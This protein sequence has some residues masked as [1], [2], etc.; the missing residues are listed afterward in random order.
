MHNSLGSRV[1][2]PSARKTQQAATSKALAVAPHELYEAA[3]PDTLLAVA[4]P[5]AGASTASGSDCFES[6]LMGFLADELAAALVH[7]HS[8]ATGSDSGL[9]ETPGSISNSAGGSELPA[10]ASGGATPWAGPAIVPPAA[11]VVDV[12][13]SGRLWD[14]RQQVGALQAQLDSLRAIT[15]MQPGSQTALPSQMPC[16]SVLPGPAAA[17]FV[18]M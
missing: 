10:A 1:T 7:E 12:N 18:C 6:M 15:G 11:P 14:L 8:T 9:A 2:K 5:A 16:F 13:I 4:G 3:A 17:S